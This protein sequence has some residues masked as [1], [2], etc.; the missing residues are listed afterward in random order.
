MK[1]TWKQKIAE[2]QEDINWNVWL[3]KQ[4]LHGYLED[5]DEVLKSLRFEKAIMRCCAKI[6]ELS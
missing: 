4:R 6:P 3:R 5:L 1:R 2:C